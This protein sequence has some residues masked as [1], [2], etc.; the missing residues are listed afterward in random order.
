MFFNFKKIFMCRIVVP[1]CI[2]VY[3]MYAWCLQKSKKSIRSPGTTG[4]TDVCELLHGYWRSNIGPLQKQQVFFFYFILVKYVWHKLVLG[5]G[6]EE[7]SVVNS[8]YI[9]TGGPKFG[10]APLPEKKIKVWPGKLCN[11]RIGGGSRSTGKSVGL[12]AKLSL[13]SVSLSKEGMS[14]H[15]QGSTP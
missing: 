15:I 7:N 3:H 6:W 12:L 9:Q 2:Y 13:G 11:H 10:S 8:T 5:G 14:C 4:V 1:T